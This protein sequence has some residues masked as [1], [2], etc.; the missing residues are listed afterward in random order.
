MNRSGKD[1]FY[2]VLC[3]D[4]YFPTALLTSGMNPIPSKW[5]LNSGS[6]NA[7]RCVKTARYSENYVKQC[8]MVLLQSWNCIW[9][10]S[11][12]THGWKLY[13]FPYPIISL[14]KSEIL[15]STI[16][17]IMF[18]VKFPD[19]DHAKPSDNWQENV[20]FVM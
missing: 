10:D 3:W 15:W 6:W 9:S 16:Q 11:L 1:Y 13:S 5:L 4:G 8:Y 7:M 12:Q 17:M 14:S 18:V 19:G 2:V 20:Q